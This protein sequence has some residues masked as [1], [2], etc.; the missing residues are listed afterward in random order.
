MNTLYT[1][2]HSNHEIAKFLDLLSQHEITALVDVRSQ[3]YSRFAPHFSK[4][5]LI[6]S[7][8]KQGIEYVFLGKELGARSDN[9][10]CYD[11]GKVQY[12]RLAE[13]P[14]FK[15]GLDRLLQGMK[16]Y[17]IEVM[18]A[19]KEPTDCHRA[20]LVA[21]KI[22]ESGIFVQHIHA[23]GHLESQEEMETRLL[24]LCK[25]PESDLFTSRS[26]NISEAYAIQG[27]K[28]AYKDESM[29]EEESA[30]NL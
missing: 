30:R 18:C 26:T 28:I 3:P 27:A 25:I 13:E 7:L 14:S 15:A 11:H 24:R 1:I 20:L 9:P 4:R 12:D 23:D 22:F 19:E 29:L 6:S 2:G 21:R 5:P 10:S 16:K 8:K 17:R